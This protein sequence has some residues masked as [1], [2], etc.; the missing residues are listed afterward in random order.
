[1]KA[2]AGFYMSNNV[3]HLCVFWFLVCFG[4]CFGFCFCF[5]FWV[6]GFWF[7]FWE[8]SAWMLNLLDVGCWILKILYFYFN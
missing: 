4:F 7:K 5:G 6:L 3:G 1:M 2:R 8:F